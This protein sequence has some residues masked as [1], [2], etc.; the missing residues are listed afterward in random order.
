MN[1]EEYTKVG[2]FGIISKTQTEKIRRYQKKLYD[3]IKIYEKTDKTIKE[4]ETLIEKIEEDINETMRKLD[5]LY[6]EG[7]NE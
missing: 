1:N 4:L 5:E 3:F 7:K 2:I 6:Q